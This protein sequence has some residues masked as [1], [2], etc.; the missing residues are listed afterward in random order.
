MLLGCIADDFTGASDL[1]NTLAREGMRTRMFIGVPDRRDHDCDAGVI[2]LKTRSVSASEAVEASLSALAWLRE[3]GCRQFVFKYCSTFDSTPQG[4]IGPVAEALANALDARGVIVCPAF[5]GAGRT[6]YQGHLFVGDRLLSESGMERHP[7]TP[8][9]DPDIRRW[10]ALQSKAVPGHVDHRAVREGQA[11]IA[12]RLAKHAD[13]GTVLVVVDAI[14][15]EDLRVIG[16]AA[17]DAVLLTGGSG[18]ALGL[19]ANFRTAGLLNNDASGFVGNDGDAVV[20]SGSCSVATREQVAKY[21]ARYPSLAI[22]PDRLLTGERVRDEAQAFLAQHKGRSPLIFSSD[23][24]ERVRAAQD[25]H[26]ASVAAGAVEELFGEL[27]ARAASTGYGRL[28][29]AGGETSGAVVTALGLRSLDIGA[30][31]DPGVPALSTVRA[32]G[33]SVALALKSGNF[34]APDFFAKAIHALRPADA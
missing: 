19:P 18:V 20:L 13:V 33:S 2:A 8:M 16:R 26:G 7:L 27:G 32:D 22:D 21:R 15:E 10:L 1:A 5:P 6:I 14:D 34:G 3:A 4:N 29:V 31:I 11:T 12:S 17:A 25:R 28:V 24:P 9:T 23:E 30:E